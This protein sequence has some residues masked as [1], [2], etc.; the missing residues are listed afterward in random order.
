[1]SKKLIGLIA[2]FL[3]VLALI[4]SP[5]FVKVTKVECSSQYGPCS[6]DIAA[7]ADKIVGK[8]LFSAKAN[9]KKELANNFEVE[10]FT[11]QYNI[12][13]ILK[14]FVVIKK[15]SFALKNETM[16]VVD[17]VDWEGNVVAQSSGSSLPTVKTDNDIA[18]PGE[19]VSESELIALKLIAGV[20][21]MYQV[22][23]GRIEGES[24]RIVLPSG[25]RVIFPIQ[26][27]TDADLLLGSLRLV[28]SKIESDS[29]GKYGEVDMRYKNPVLR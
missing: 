6:Q 29:P 22:S 24:L 27:G 18:K 2:V 14:V 11:T 12:P 25:L 4:V 28:E 15:P 7:N 9:I 16:G 5:F 10:R 13:S 8:S 3:P 21:Q 26:S 17:L 23:E 19:K 1:V 20:Y